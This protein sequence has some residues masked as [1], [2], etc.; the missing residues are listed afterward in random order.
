VTVTDTADAPASTITISYSGAPVTVNPRRINR[1]MWVPNLG[2]NDPLQ[3]DQRPSEVA[4]SLFEQAKTARA[5]VIPDELRAECYS[6]DDAQGGG[7][8]LAVYPTNGTAG[9]TCGWRDV[10]NIVCPECDTRPDND[11]RLVKEA[12]QFMAA[13][14]N[15]ALGVQNNRDT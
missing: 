7:F 15:A 10:E 6:D 12:L 2:R 4:A 3:A 13:E 1:E 9:V 5:L 11:R 8:I 14:M